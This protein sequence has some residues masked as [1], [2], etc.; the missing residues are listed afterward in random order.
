MERWG[1]RWDSNPR[2]PG[3]Q[4]GAL[5]AELRPPSTCPSQP[6][7]P[8]DS[9]GAIM[10]TARRC[11]LLVPPLNKPLKT[12]TYEV[13]GPRPPRFQAPFATGREVYTNF[14]RVLPPACRRVHPQ[15]VQVPVPL[16]SLRATAAH[17]LPP[18]GPLPATPGEAT[19]MPLVRIDALEGRSPE[20]I[21]TLLDAVH[22]A[23]V[24]A[25]TAFHI[26]IR[27]RDSRPTPCSRAA[28]SRRP[29]VAQSKAL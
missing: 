13:A 3:S 12:K 16:L 18:D 25:V 1:G 26:P 21:A 9:S 27:D 5:P 10:G 11:R 7:Y 20:Q 22:R 23:P 28:A 6:G 4:P 8:G 15:G 29:V 14:R 24:T 2:Q 17:C 19:R